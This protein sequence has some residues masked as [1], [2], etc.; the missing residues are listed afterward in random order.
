MRLIRPTPPD[1]WSPG[2]DLSDEHE[3]GAIHVDFHVRAFD[4]A[5]GGKIV[6]D[7]IGHNL[8]V[9]KG[10]TRMLTQLAGTTT[11]PF[12]SMGVGVNNTAAGATDVRLDAAATGN[13][14]LIACDATFPSVTA[15]GTAPAVATFQATWGTGVANFQWNE[16]AIF[17]GTVNN[18]SIMYDR[19]V[20]GPF[21]K[22]SSVSI[23]L[24]AAITQS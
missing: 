23:V 8:V 5:Q 13:V 18:T 15:D 2:E 14:S 20:F 21:T 9:N 17:N 12:T 10:K 11:A 22:S 4:H 6:W 1:L 24:S 3:V 19:S 16:W 7:E